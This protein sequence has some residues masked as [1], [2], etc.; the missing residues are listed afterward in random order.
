MGT[1][2]IGVFFA[3]LKGFPFGKYVAEGRNLGRIRIVH[4]GV[5]RNVAEDLAHVGEQVTFV[6]LCDESAVGRDMLAHLRA[7]GVDTRYVAQVQENGV[8]MW[9]VILDE[10]GNLA[11]SI[12]QMPDVAAL[13]ALL[14]EK[15]EEIV[16]GADN[17]VLE[18]DL[19]AA[20]A[21]QVLDLARRYG[22]KA[23]AI[24]GNMSVIL[25]HPEYLRV[26]DCFVCNEV[27]AGRLFGVSDVRMDAEE[28]LAV[29][30]EAMARLDIPAM[31]VTLGAEG[32]VFYDRRTGES[33]RC[34]TLASEVVD[35]S[36]A[37]DAFL[38]GLVAARGRGLSL[39]GAVR[40]AS[41]LAAAALAQEES[42]APPMELFS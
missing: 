24:V 21:A 35:S 39:E 33:G 23:Y 34:P 1:V 32:A 18:I 7:Q 31:V 17:L 15:G 42:V 16:R 5:C 19:S 10:K 40:A 12:S 37:G 26:L 36:G 41:K 14:R 11:G 6:S 13:E 8:G 20:V 30:P 29:L 28:L 27:E 9:L 25:A 4:G 2:A 3:D 38:A 22:K